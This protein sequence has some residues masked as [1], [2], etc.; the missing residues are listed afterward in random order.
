MF[1]P[2]PSRYKLPIVSYWF[3]GK[4][5][6]K[7]TNFFQ[8]EVW[9]QIKVE[10][11]WLILQDIFH[12]FGKTKFYQKFWSEETLIEVPGQIFLKKL[13]YK[14]QCRHST[15]EFRKRCFVEILVTSYEVF[16]FCFFPEKFRK[17]MFSKWSF[18]SWWWKNKCLF[19]ATDFRQFVWEPMTKNRPNSVNTFCFQTFSKSFGLYLRD[20][21]KKILKSISVNFF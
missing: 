15:S 2:A 14:S 17:W 11:N 7:N 10:V 20:K 13:I 16:R 6:L 3:I 12:L 1:R 5:K 9:Y 4:G 21:K 18:I 8:I 19:I